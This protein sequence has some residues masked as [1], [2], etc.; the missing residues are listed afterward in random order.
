MLAGLVAGAWYFI[1]STGVSVR[2][3]SIGS[4]KDVQLSIPSIN[5]NTTNGADKGGASTSFVFNKEGRFKIDIL[6]TIGDL[7]GG[8]C[9]NASS[10]C[11]VTYWLS[12]GLVVKS[13]FNG[14][15]LDIPANQNLKVIM[16]NLSCVAYSC[17]QTRDINIKLT[18]MS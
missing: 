6:E 13:I 5:L 11:N 8:Q 15:N 2:I 10:D 14:I 3:E 7:S 4:Q 18:Q 16:A 9:M 17:P 12:D 1:F